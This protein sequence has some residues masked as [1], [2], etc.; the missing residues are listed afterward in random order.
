MLAG[1]ALA[2]LT[3]GT[4]LAFLGATPLASALTVGGVTGLVTGDLRQGLMAGLGAYGGAGL[5]AGLAKTGAAAGASGATGATG[6]TGT[7]AGATGTA[8]GAGASGTGTSLF[9]SSANTFGNVAK[10]T[11]PFPTSIPTDFGPAGLQTAVPKVPLN[12]NALAFRPDYV[13][14]IPGGAAPISTFGSIG[15]GITA[16]PS[17]GSNMA[18]GVKALG[19]EGGLGNLYDALPGGTLPAI[20]GS[21]MLNR[22]KPAE[23]PKTDPGMIRPYNYERTQNQAAYDMGAPMYSSTPGSSAERNYFTDSYT[24]LKPYKAPGPEYAAEGGLMGFAVGGPIETMSAMNSVGANTGYP[25]AGINTA[26]YSNPMIQRPEAV[27]VIAPSGDAGVGAYSG[28]PKF[29]SGGGVFAPQMAGGYNYSYDPNTMQFTQTGTPR[30]VYNTFGSALG[31]VFNTLTGR[32]PTFDHGPKVSGGIAKPAAAPA[33]PAQPAYTPPSIPA[34]KPPEQQL[35]LGSFYSMMNSQLGSPKFSKGGTA[36]DN[37]AKEAAKLQGEYTYSYNPQ[38]MRF[39]ELGT[40]TSPGEKP[41]VEM[42]GMAPPNAN[43]PAMP[44]QP[45]YGAPPVSAYQSP[46]QQLGL[47]DFY[48]MMDR[49]LGQVG[50]YAA[51]GGVSHLGDY[52]DGGR[53]LKGP[54][55]GVSDSIPAVIGNRQPARLADGEFVVPAR[56]VSELGNGS[57]EAGARKLYAMMD[58]VQK[59][60]RKTVGKSRVAANTRSEKYLPA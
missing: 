57:T 48:A 60:R 13:A 21:L 24:E 14:P 10:G 27:N 46:E 34:Y 50:G 22:D 51:G 45:A 55:D 54:G 23:P 53:L 31:K 41:K 59:A 49:R 17:M 43:S 32:Q 8:A 1:L 36:A 38:T 47:T 3:A 11:G 9:P 29:A 52:S 58:R 7:A 25:M 5:G 33:M 42:G 26:L 30:P 35:G 19:Q 39:T 56:I 15:Q 4:S 16:A 20:A 2:P 6:A 37:A 40:P 28:E 18:S 12:P 44:A